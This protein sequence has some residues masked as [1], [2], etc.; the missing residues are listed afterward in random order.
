[1][2]AL[3]KFQL[4]LALNAEA[5]LGILIGLGLHDGGRL[6]LQTLTRGRL[7]LLQ[8]LLLL[9][10]LFG[11]I[12]IFILEGF[13]ELVQ[14]L[15]IG[16]GVGFLEVGGPLAPVVMLYHIGIG[17]I[18][19]EVV[20]GLVLS[21]IILKVLVGG[22]GESVSRGRSHH[23]D[24]VVPKSLPFLVPAPL[25]DLSLTQAGLPGHL[26]K[27]LLGPVWVPLE[28]S[29]QVLQLVA[30]LPLSLS[31][32]PLIVSLISVNIRPSNQVFVWLEAF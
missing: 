12:N 20:G 13:G 15:F 2:L 22:G 32:N 9:L 18:Q 16:E 26:K 19:V 4:S 31:D 6:R 30:R 29:H 8:L 27:G 23:H 5:W 1:M 10:V 14:L 25:V 3:M 21:D 28:L 17:L 11:E 7:E 24:S